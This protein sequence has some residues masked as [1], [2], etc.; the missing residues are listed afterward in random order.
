MKALLF[1][2]LIFL[3]MNIIKSIPFLGQSLSYLSSPIIRKI[4]NNKNL[5][6][7]SLI[8]NNDYDDNNFIS[9]DEEEKEA[10]SFRGK[11]FS[12]VREEIKRLNIDESKDI[13][14]GCKNVI[15]RYLIGQIYESNSSNSSNISYILSDFHL[16]KLLDDSSKSRN[17]LVTYDQCM[18][19]KYKMDIDQFYER[20]ES[21]NTYVIL[22]YDNTTIPENETNKSIKTL[23][24]EFKYYLIAICLPQGNRTEDNETEYCTDND[25]KN[26]ILYINE[27]YNNFLNISY[28]TSIDTFSLRKYPH[29]S[30]KDSII[31]IIIHSIP[32]FIFSLQSL[33]I[34][35]RNCI[36]QCI[37][38]KK[39]IIIN[40]K[41]IREFDVDVDDSNDNDEDNISFSKNKGNTDLND[42]EREN[43][44]KFWKC[45]SLSENGNEL[46]DFSLTSTKYNNDSGL[47]NIRGMKGLSIICM[48][49]GWTF[50]ILFNCPIKVYSTYHIKSFFNSIFSYFVMIGVRYSPR[51]VISCSGY[52]LI[53]K[54]LSYLDRNYIKNTVSIFWTSFTFVMYQLHKYLLFILLLFFQRY[55]LYHFLYLIRTDKSIEDGNTPIWKYYHLYIASS[56]SFWQFLLSFTMLRDFFPNEE[57]Q[58]KNNNLL[59]YFWLP[60]NEIFFFIFGVIFIT[61]GYKKQ[62][63]IDIIILILVPL[64]LILKTVFSYIVNISDKNAPLKVYFPTLYY[65]FY[66]YGRFMINPIFNLPYFLIGMFFGLVNYAIQK[67]INDLSAPQT[68]SSFKSLKEKTSKDKNIDNKDNKDNNDN[69]DISQDDTE[70]E[71]K[72]IKSNEE[73]NEEQN[74][75]EIEYS[76]EV[77]EKPFLIRPILFI[78]WHRKHGMISL[79][80][81]LVIF[82][83]IILA[84]IFIYHL[85]NFDEDCNCI[86]CDCK[87]DIINIFINFIYRID[88]EFVIIFVQ[89]GAFII[90]LKVNN[91]L[92]IFLGHISWTLLTKPYFSFILTINT[93][94]LFIFYQSETMIEINYM[95]II[96]YS[97]I[98]GAITFSLTISFYILFELPY[99][100]IMHLLFSS[101]KNYNDNNS[102]IDDNTNS[103]FDNDLKKND[104]NED[105]DDESDNQ[106]KI[107][108]D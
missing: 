74:K 31:K 50:V 34:L 96:L 86:I 9:D 37:K 46:F 54:Y 45:F 14:I 8:E 43:K 32:F 27:K 13:K 55:S 25:Y 94:L 61:I 15:K 84:F 12:L 81:L 85:Y 77:I 29:E 67:G 100:R 2:M 42:N 62:W 10:K 103:S 26:L 106:I 89:W 83:V 71:Y 99:K 28:N 21:K 63:R 80:I 1:I 65:V 16:I 44:N 48:I 47:S 82:V 105:E 49:F 22:R 75:K 38:R 98:G 24:I 97:L 4:I 23:E 104:S 79:S 107:K 78:K 69:N 101:K 36:K 58:R 76:E 3:L 39:K 56:P 93:V 7:L 92:A 18:I 41:N 19:K 5:N 11:L 108:N 88:I 60:F 33:F 35:F 90:F 59:Q 30:E 91:F 17:Y 68:G 20:E 87:T 64:L 95:N 52:I 72:S 70:G 66:N 53:Y 57:E 73:S 6:I 51:I 40:N 102:T